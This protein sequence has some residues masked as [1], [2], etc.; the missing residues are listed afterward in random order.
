MEASVHDARLRIHS[1]QEWHDLYQP[2]TNDELQLFFDRYTKGIDNGFE[3][4]VP[5][6]R[7]SLIGYNIV[8]LGPKAIKG[9]C[10]H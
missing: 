2:S 3:Q 8:R 10:H 6:V 5:K 9:L 1:T 7:A 4:R